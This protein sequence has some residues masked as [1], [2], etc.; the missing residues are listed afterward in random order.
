[1]HKLT[2]FPIG[3]ADCC[4]VEVE[5]G[6]N[7]LFDYA[8]M[9]CKED[10]NDLRIDLE[11][12]IKNKLES[13]EK[14]YFDVVSFSHADKDHYNK[15]SELFYLEHANKYQSEERI[16]INEM[17][18]PATLI[19][20]G[21]LED[22]GKILRTEAR[23]RF[24]NKTGIKVFSRPE[25]LKNWCEQENLNI[26]EYNGLLVDAGNL[27]PGFN[28]END[29]V[30]FFVHSPFANRHDDGTLTDRN[31]CSIV[32]QASFKN[33]EN[34]TRVILS[35]DTI[36]EA[37]DEIVKITKYHKNEQ[38]LNYDVFELSH[39]CSYLSLSDEKGKDKTIPN[40]N[41]D[42]IFKQGNKGAILISTSK[43]IPSND[44]DTQPPHRQAANYYKDIAKELEGHFVVTMEHPKRSKP[45]PVVITIEGDGATLKKSSIGAAAYISSKAGPRAG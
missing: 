45:E 35:A 29:G 40:E 25:V 31:D 14:N 30:E 26:D 41:I 7:L 2:F 18:V 10:D 15:F 27:V 37:W 8:N 16:K 3:N 19:C 28:I 12:A 21:D 1:M 17:W 23:Y 6:K 5:S 22:E 9:L 32:V 36:W 24:K 44:D 33:N 11:T 39:H 4:F 34:I 42:W 20:D 43:P 13:L 38:R